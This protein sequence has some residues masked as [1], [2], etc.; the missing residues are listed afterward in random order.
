MVV[1]QAI[2][3][4]IGL[5]VSPADMAAE[6]LREAR[7]TGQG[8]A[9]VRD[10]I[11]ATDIDTAYDV[12]MI[13]LRIA[14]GHGRTLIGSKIGL[15]SKAVQAQFGVYEPD[16]GVL[17]DHMLIP[18]NQLIDRATLI[19][20]RIEAEVVFHLDA[21]LDNTEASE[22]DVINASDWIAPAFEIVD[23]RIADW[24]ITI[25][26]TIA[27]NASAGLVVLGAERTPTRSFGLDGL[28]SV[29]VRVCRDGEQISTGTGVTCMGN[30]A[31]AMAWLARERARR[32]SPL[33]SGELVLSGA[34]GPMVG[35]DTDGRFTADFGDFGSVSTTFGSQLDKQDDL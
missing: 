14:L 32:G 8:C 4:Q 27:D 19:A 33:K 5:M 26:D 17:L 31:V 9:P 25:T 1:S 2:A 30:P 20:P 10:L 3:P 34:L 13:Q 6:R 29:E 22:A 21:D 35:V 7:R 16:F 11:G 23:S 18:Q 28:A 15:T 12:Q 24:D